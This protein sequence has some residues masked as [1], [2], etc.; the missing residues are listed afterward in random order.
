MAAEV[1]VGSRKAGTTNKAAGNPADTCSAVF[2]LLCSCTVT[3]TFSLQALRVDLVRN[4]QRCHCH[5]VLSDAREI[6]IVLA[7]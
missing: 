6:A 1:D 3:A 5:V 7:M 2:V 4:V